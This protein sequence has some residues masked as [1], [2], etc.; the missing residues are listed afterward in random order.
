MK[1]YGGVEAYLH[2]S[3]PLHWTE[4]SIKFQP[5]GRFNPDGMSFRHPWTRGWADRRA[6][7][8][9][10]L[11]SAGNWTPAA[12]L[13]TRCYTDRTIPFEIS[14]RQLEQINESSS[15]LDLTSFTY[16]LGLLS[17]SVHSSDYNV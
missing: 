6:C 16:D 11:T 4:M 13:V 2:H 17:D 9:A 12:L 15:L 8:H 3:S 5:P 7:L 14:G 10:M 1:E